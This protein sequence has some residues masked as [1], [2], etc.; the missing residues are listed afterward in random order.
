M[1]CHLATTLGLELSLRSDSR[2]MND[3]A[4][5][6]ADQDEQ[7]PAT[8]V[9]KKQQQRAERANAAH[10]ELREGRVVEA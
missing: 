3:F 4:A 9:L 7:R 1:I 10:E 5:A 8:F 6:L 2:R